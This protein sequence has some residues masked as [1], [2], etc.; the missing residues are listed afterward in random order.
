MKVIKREGYLEDFDVSRIKSAI[1]KAMLATNRYDE[2]ILKQ[3]VNYILKILKERYV[4]K[5]PHV[6]E[7]QDIVEFTLMKFGL[8][9]TAKA[10]VLYRKEREK[11]REEKKKILNKKILDFVDKS[12]SL[13]ALRILAYRYLQKNEDNEIIETPKQLFE[14]VAMLVVIPD[15]LYDVRIFDK[16]GKKIHKEEKFDPEKY[17]GKIGLGRDKNTYKVTW[18]KWHLIQ[19]KK[20]YDELNKESKMRVPWKKFFEMLK[21][22]AFEKYYKNFLVYFNLMI[23]KKFIPNSPTLFNAGTRLAQLSACFVLPIYDNIE[24]IMNAAKDAAI[25]FK[26]GGGVGI[27]YS[28]LR[29]EG[30]VVAS[31]S[32]VASGPISFMRI[33]DVVT[34]V[35]KQGGKRRGANM[36]ILEVWHPD[37]EKF[38]TLKSVEGVFENFN[39]SVMLN[40]EFIKKLKYHNDFDLINPR[41][42]NVV[43]KV[44]AN[45]LFDLI[46]QN[47]W[48][49]G[50]PGVLFLDNINKYN[51]LRSVL[52]DIKAT[53]P[54]GEQP[55]YPYDSCN[56][57]S[58]NLYAMIKEDENGKKYF[59]WNEYIKTITWAYRFLDNIID[60]NEFPLEAIKKRNKELRNIGLGVMGLADCL[61]AL[62]LAYNS[63]EGFS[64]M[65][66]FIEYLTYYAIK[67]S[68]RRSK[69]RGTFALFK[70]SGYVEG[71]LPVAGFYKKR[72]WTL[73]W[74]KLVDK[75]KRGMRNANL[76]TIAPTGSLSMICDVSSGIEPQFALVYEKIVTVGRFYYIDEE[77]KEQLQ[78][79]KLYR[80]EIIK[81]VAENAGSIQLIKNIPKKMKEI[82]VTAYD[83]PWWDHIRAQYEV[84][85][86]TTNSISKTINMPNWVSIEDVKNAYLFAYK[87]GLKGLTIYRDGSKTK[88][89][90]VTPTQKRHR[91][92]SIKTNKTLEMAEKFGIKLSLSGIKKTSLV[93]KEKKAVMKLTNNDNHCPVCSSQLIYEE[94]CVSCPSC[95][96]SACTLG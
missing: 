3:C 74:K 30:D 50:D 33:I 84:Q 17:D 55:L 62:K 19:M 68:I 15:I 27:N 38:I 52:G 69:E 22:G 23:E 43:K 80:E 73:D 20:L 4:K 90:L 65:R 10:Y 13:N 75:V 11:I 54:C 29:P 96:W 46:A 66:K 24:S 95:G 31:T 16:H 94:G 36:G 2:T 41:N 53:N 39:I 61:F 37:I 87:L 71:K 7:I 21:Q 32:G 18:N 34:D 25:I 67:E 56:L 72:Y 28:N 58:I 48:K 44:N 81:Q 8:F 64:L 49:S 42:K 77:F 78:K 12:F 83:I 60:V 45:Y 14:R 70:K 79:S 63:E 85:L 26:T 47:A 82:F 76:T 9:E 35:I 86:W 89:V 40:N 1:K 6:E 57:G 51:I 5:N 88:Q 91:Y 92:V 93:S 59:D